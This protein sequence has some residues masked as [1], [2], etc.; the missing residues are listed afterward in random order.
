MIIANDPTRLIAFQGAHGAY[1]DLACRQVYP[2]MSTLPCAAFE[3]AI[4][5]VRDGITTDCD[6]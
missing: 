5:V 4:A 2:E 6:D 1:S 3:D